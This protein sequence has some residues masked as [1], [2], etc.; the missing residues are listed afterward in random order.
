MANYNSSQYVVVQFDKEAIQ[1]RGYCVASNSTLRADCPDPSLR[2]SG[3]LEMN[4]QTP[5]QPSFM[6]PRHLRERPTSETMCPHGVG[7]SCRTESIVSADIRTAAPTG[8]NHPVK[9]QSKRIPSVPVQCTCRGR[10]RS[11]DV[12]NA[13][14]CCRLELM[15]VADVPSVALSCTPAANARISTPPADSNAANRFRNGFREKTSATNA[16][17]TRCVYGLKR[18]LPL[19]VQLDQWMRARPSRIYSRNKLMVDPATVA[20]NS[21]FQ[22]WSYQN[23]AGE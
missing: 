22:R 13:G 9:S 4:N 8:R 7:L 1:A 2:K 3:L 5:P 21:R 14:L 6:R 18:K 10:I 16:R 20:E 17:S 12:P 23:F 15:Q 19:R 11:R